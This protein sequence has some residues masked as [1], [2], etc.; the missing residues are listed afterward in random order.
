MCICGGFSQI[1][2]HKYTYIWIHDMYITILLKDSFIICKHLLKK[3][4]ENFTFIMYIIISTEIHNEISIYLCSIL[5]HVQ[6]V[7]R[8]QTAIFLSVR[9]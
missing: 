2:S 5:T 8:G 4:M 9:G 6:I 7:S 1:L 3:S